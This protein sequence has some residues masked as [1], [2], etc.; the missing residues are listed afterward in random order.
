MKS[1]PVQA[2]DLT[3]LGASDFNQIPREEENLIQSSGQILL[4]SDLNQMGKAAA[5]YG[6]DGDAY[7]DV[8]S[9]NA[10]VLIATGSKQSI[11]NL[12]L[13]T[14]IRF[15]ATNTN[16]SGVVTVTVPG[17]SSI[18]ISSGKLGNSPATPY[19]APGDI[20]AGYWVTI[21]YGITDD[22]L[23]L[24]FEVIQ[25]TEHEIEDN[26]VTADKLASNAVTTAKILNDN[27]TDAKIN[28][29]SLSKVTAGEVNLRNDPYQFF[30]RTSAPRLLFSDP[31]SYGGSGSYI[32]LTC[33][34]GSSPNENA[35]EY[36][37]YSGGNGIRKVLI[38]TA[39]VEVRDLISSHAFQTETR[40]SENGITWSDGPGNNVSNHSRSEFNFTTTW[41]NIVGH[42]TFIWGTTTSLTTDIPFGAEIKSAVY[43][44]TSGGQQYSAPM[45]YRVQDV[46]D[47][48][49]IGEILVTNKSQPAPNGVVE[50][51][52]DATL[53]N[54]L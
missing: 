29:V 46:S 23:T 50:V 18:R 30:L 24:Y 27:V 33:G 52:Y 15:R 32:Q 36:E 54:S 38:F 19:V 45:S 21:V 31:N 39:G 22:S 8:G 35:L 16:T 7:T 43:K 41:G 17:Q 5:K 3:S 10:H 26:A 34:N 49:V 13:G 42:D 1:I 11:P 48:S 20:K 25:I 53:L 4:E 37:F 14:R 9:A 47:D 44:W 51:C 2:D 12:N 28:D 6:C 40:L